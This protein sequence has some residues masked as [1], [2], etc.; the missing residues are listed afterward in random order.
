MRTIRAVEQSNLVLVAF[1]SNDG[2]TEDTCNLLSLS[3]FLVRLLED[4]N[5]SSMSR[6]LMLLEMCEAKSRDGSSADMLSIETTK[7]RALQ[8]FQTLL[9]QSAP[10]ADTGVLLE[11]SKSLTV[12]QLYPLRYAA[13]SAAAGPSNAPSSTASAASNAAGG[14]IVLRKSTA[15]GRSISHAG[16][17]AASSSSNLVTIPLHILAPAT[18]ITEA[19]SLT[20]LPALMYTIQTMQ[21]SLCAKNL[22]RNE[23]FSF[24]SA[25]SSVHQPGSATSSLSSLSSPL[26]SIRDYS[27]SSSGSPSPLVSPVASTSSFTA[28]PSSSIAPPSST[29]GSAAQLRM[30]TLS[31]QLIAIL[32]RWKNDL[33]SVLP[34]LHASLH[35]KAQQCVQ[36]AMAEFPKFKQSYMQTDEACRIM[37]NPEHEG[38]FLGVDMVQLFC[39]KLLHEIPQ[40][41]HTLVVARSTTSLEPVMDTLASLLNECSAMVNDDTSPLD[42]MRYQKL[43]DFFKGVNDHSVNNRIQSLQRELSFDTLQ[44]TKEACV[45][46]LKVNI[47]RRSRSICGVR[48]YHKLVH[49]Y[50]PQVPLLAE[51]GLPNAET[52]L[53]IG[54]WAPANTPRPIVERLSREI[55]TITGQADTAQRLRKMGVDP[56]AEGPET[57][58]KRVQREVPLYRQVIEAAGVATN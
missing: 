54:V 38:R 26:G 6:R 29:T 34:T 7:A 1:D 37:L 18:T 46:S 23:R 28:A 10:E 19:K 58:A 30:Q 13:L 11:L 35:H 56:T 2:L 52:D 41:W 53:F 32:S 39:G 57:L 47:L 55:L 4:R 14:G 49:D 50:L 15:A 43:L 48:Q 25:S 24:S 40:L 36:R 8:Q 45:N 22:Q 9:E 21:L 31:A 27:S 51:A 12:L 44:A 42:R 17:D 3:S 5:G 16:S 33:A 20:H